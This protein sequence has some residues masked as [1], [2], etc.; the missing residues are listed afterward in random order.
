MCAMRAPRDLHRSTTVVLSSVMV[1]LG[2][3]MIVVALVA[4]GGP[5][6]RGLLLG[7]LFVAAGV[8]RIWVARQ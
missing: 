1:L 8:G 4:A 3:A 6:T 2:L 7:V 5:G